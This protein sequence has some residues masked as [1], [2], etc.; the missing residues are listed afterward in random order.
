MRTT[1]TAA[2]LVTP[3]ECVENPVVVVEDGI[4][5]QV[6]TRDAAELPSQSRTVDFP[7]MVLAPAYI[8]LHI[9]G[10]AGHDVMEPSAAGLQRMEKQLTGHGVAAYLP[11]A[12]TAPHSSLL[13]ALEF[14][15]K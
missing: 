1:I 15:G 5:D 9:H 10:G 8:D 7:G 3:E 6:L 2:R 14:L 11:T 13:R 12:V 4:V